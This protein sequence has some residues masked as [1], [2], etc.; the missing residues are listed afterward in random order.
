V[1]GLTD[2][3][4]SIAD[5]F[6]QEGYIAFAPD[7]LS[8]DMD[9]AKA[10]ELEPDMHNPE[11]RTA[12]QPKLSELMAPIQ[13]PDFAAKTVESLKKVFEGL[14]EMPESKQKVAIIGFC[15]SG[16]YSF[17]LAVAESRLSQALAFYGHS[18]QSV[19]ELSKI[20]CPVMAFYG[21]NDER[22]INGLPDLKS[23]MEQAKVNFNYKV[24]PDCG[25][26]FFNDSNPYSYNKSA[27]D[28]AWT[29]VLDR[30]P[31]D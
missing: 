7:L 4:K 24:Y 17:S 14:Y 28:D 22:L 21:E 25:H 18:D 11:K 26:A 8:D 1:W 16:T 9:I 5:R 12:V 20:S 15:F 29:I 31:K 6:A 13:S 2:H 27:A 23:R 19:E 30:L 10:Q 3:I